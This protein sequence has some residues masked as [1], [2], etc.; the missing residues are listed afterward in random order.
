M[1]LEFKDVVETVTEIGVMLKDAMKTIA[2]RKATVELG[3]GIDV[4]TG[5]LTAYFV[6]AGMS[7]CLKVTLEWGDA[8]TELA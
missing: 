6:E 7:G 5:R 2:P 1:H 3:I 8:P 4:K